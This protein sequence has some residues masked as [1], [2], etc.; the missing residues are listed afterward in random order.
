MPKISVIIPVYN[1]MQYLREC[2]DSVIAQ[3]IK[4]IEIICVNDGSTDDSYVILQ[5]YE[6]KDNR[7]RIFNQE[8]KGAGPARN[9]A[10]SNATGEYVAFMDPDD[11][12]PDTD[13]LETLYNKAVQ[14]RA[15]ICGG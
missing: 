11:S 1:V 13:I 9:K 7:I 15:D 12:Y 6:A 3:T 4:D 2:L 8:N 5:E 14:N 10:I